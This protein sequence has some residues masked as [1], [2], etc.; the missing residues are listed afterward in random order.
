MECALGTKIA[1]RTLS[2]KVRKLLRAVG[3]LD[4]LKA[5]ELSN[6]ITQVAMV[7]RER[8]IELRGINWKNV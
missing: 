3:R 4:I 2:D 8:D 6:Y 7:E 5:K 1:N